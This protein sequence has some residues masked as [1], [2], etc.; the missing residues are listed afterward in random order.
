MSYLYG[1]MRDIVYNSM[2][3]EKQEDE[4]YIN[5][6]I[7]YDF[8]GPSI[9]RHSILCPATNI[10]VVNNNNN[11]PSLAKDTVSDNNNVTWE[12]LDNYRADARFHIKTD[13]TGFSTGLCL[14]I[15]QWKCR[16]L[17]VPVC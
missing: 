9:L 10:I 4:P 14:K 8:E 3:T 17:E 12:F 15:N 1:E 6:K 5:T 11:L 13:K 7:L 2:I 16:S